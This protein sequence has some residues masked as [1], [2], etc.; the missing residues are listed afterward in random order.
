MFTCSKSDV[1][2]I[3]C[4]QYGVMRGL[5]LLLLF[6]FNVKIYAV[7]PDVRDALVT[8]Y[9]KSLFLEPTHRS[10]C[11][12]AHLDRFVPFLNQNDRN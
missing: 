1:I 4:H 2:W 11:S 6:S 8:R 7:M 10:K 12:E 3:K 9:Q 5:Q